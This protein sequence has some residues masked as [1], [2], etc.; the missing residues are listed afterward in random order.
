MFEE[1]REDEVITY[2][3]Y[4]E[5]YGAINAQGKG[6]HFLAI[7][8]LDNSVKRF[9]G[10]MGRY[11]LLYRELTK[12]CQ[13]ERDQA[14]ACVQYSEFQYFTKRELKELDTD[15]LFEAFNLF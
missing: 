6:K 11:E 5:E 8:K 14:W 4:I 9:D 1:E 12:P 2:E 13:S 15:N 3:E 7:T 10:K